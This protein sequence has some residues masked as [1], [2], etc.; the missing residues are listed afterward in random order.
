M[1][2]ADVYS[3]C[4]IYHRPKAFDESS[5]ESDITSDEESGH[6]RH[7]ANG[8]GK[9]KAVGGEESSESEGG[10]GNGAAK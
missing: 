2:R 1:H 7:L 8:K 9:G 6:A 3:V 4:C 5:S 10:M